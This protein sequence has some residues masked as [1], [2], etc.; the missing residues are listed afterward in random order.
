MSITVTVSSNVAYVNMSN[1][2]QINNLYIY[3]GGYVYIYKWKFY[4][5]N[6]AI[7]H[8]FRLSNAPSLKRLLRVVFI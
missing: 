5:Q 8:F 7:N 1:V 4:S 3:V 6:S 2:Q